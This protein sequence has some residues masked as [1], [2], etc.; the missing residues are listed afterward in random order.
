MKVAVSVNRVGQE[1]TSNYDIPFRHKQVLTGNFQER[2]VLR[3][4][5]IWW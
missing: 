2:A 1:K 3:S 5:K 4:V